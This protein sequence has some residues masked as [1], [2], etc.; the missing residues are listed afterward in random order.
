VPSE[1]GIREER[2]REKS[3]CMP[4]DEC[5]RAGQRFCGT[6]RSAVYDTYKNGTPE[7]AND[8]NCT[9]WGHY[10]SYSEKKAPSRCGFDRVTDAHYCVA[11]EKC[12]D[13]F[14]CG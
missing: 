13:D 2:G 14:Y 6:N 4:L 8:E 7:C 9:F 5:K 11:E 12:A 10:W 3:W 1:C